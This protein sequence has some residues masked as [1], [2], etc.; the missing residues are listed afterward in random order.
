[1]ISRS[2]V[3]AYRDRMIPR[4]R[5]AYELYLQSYREM[6]AA[7]P[8]VLIAQRTL[9]QL[10]TDYVTALANLWANSIALKGFLLTD[11]LESPSRAGEMDRPV[12]ELNVP[13]STAVMQS[14]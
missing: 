8:Q 4:A 10:Q 1:M 12:R 3:E 5:K 7:Y 2:T 9:F 13:S 11:G 14:Q 6:A